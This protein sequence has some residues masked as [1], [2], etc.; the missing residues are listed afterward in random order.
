MQL[1]KELISLDPHF[2]DR[3][4][5]Y[6]ARFK[7]LQLKLGKYGKNYQK[8]DGQLIKLVLMNLR[9]PFDLL[10]STFRTNWQARKEDGKDYTFEAFCGLLIN[11]QH[12]LLEEGKLGGKHQAH[13]LKG[14]SKLDPRDRVRFDASPQKP[15]YRDQKP[16][17]HD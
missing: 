9:T 6:L 17:Y 13:L 14:N 15:V 8:N 5:D 4:E 2:F 16:T 3:I 10:V 11:D 7:E 1:E 12:K